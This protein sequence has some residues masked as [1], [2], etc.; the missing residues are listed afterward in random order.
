V[1]AFQQ[2][3]A[4][5]SL[6]QFNKLIF[7]EDKLESVISRQNLHIFCAVFEKTQKMGLMIND[8]CTK[9]WT[10]KVSATEAISEIFLVEIFFSLSSKSAWTERE[11]I[12]SQ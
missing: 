6:R 10:R 12:Q 7:S 9:H 4:K 11:S 8:I 1:K 2:L 3:L 5:K